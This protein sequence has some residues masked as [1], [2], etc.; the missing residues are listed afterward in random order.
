[1]TPDLTGQTFGRYV[2]L[3]RAPADRYRSARWLCRCSCGAEKSIRSVDLRKGYVVSC[4]CY[5]RDMAI[6]LGHSK[7]THGAC[8]DE[9]SGTPEYQAWLHMKGRVLNSNNR[10]YHHY[11][12]RGILICDRWLHSFENFLADMGQRP[13]N[14]EG[15]SSKRPYYSL[16]RIDNNGNY[17][18]GNCRWA[19]ISEQSGNRRP[20]KHTKPRKKVP[21]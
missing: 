6:A 21:S 17:E 4:G 13:P 3:R 20:Y 11:G 2:V 7:Q 8:I 12:G 16:D 19:T 15:W 9:N 18:P 14:P 10:A 5:N 1:M